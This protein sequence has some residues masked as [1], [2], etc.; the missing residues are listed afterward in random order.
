MRQLTYMDWVRYDVRSCQSMHFC[1]ICNKDIVASERYYDGGYGRRA[2]VTC[3][4]SL[5]LDPS[6]IHHVASDGK[7]EPAN[8]GR[9]DNMRTHEITKREDELIRLCTEAKEASK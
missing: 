9:K 7:R 8:A 6:E 5:D 1:R 4:H 2:H 3:V